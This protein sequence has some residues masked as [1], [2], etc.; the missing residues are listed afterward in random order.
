MLCACPAKLFIRLASIF[1]LACSAAGQELNEDLARLCPLVP[2]ALAQAIAEEAEG[3]GRCN[4]VCSGC[5]CKGGPGYR[6]N[7][8]CVSWKHLIEEC[9]PPPHDRCEAECEPV[10]RGCHGRAWVKE[11]AAKAGLEIQFVP[12]KQR[13]KAHSKPQPRNGTIGSQLPATAKHDSVF[14]CEGKRRCAE[15][16]SCEEATFYLISCGVKSLDGDH[17]GTPCNSLCR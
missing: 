13:T 15:M 6:K 12:G 10:K 9:G 16:L 2:P 11:I 3:K 4:V 5:G 14:K 1:A 8:N 7:N 17:D